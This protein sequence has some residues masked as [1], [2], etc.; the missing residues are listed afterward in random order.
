M[1][2]RTDSDFFSL[3][4]VE[5]AVSN[6]RA[7]PH[8]VHLVNDSAWKQDSTVGDPTGA[9]P[10]NLSKSCGLKKWASLVELSKREIKAIP[11][12]SAD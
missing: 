8:F 5:R 9:P 4:H 7:C 3:S 11:L 12:W 6:R 1:D 10:A 2:T